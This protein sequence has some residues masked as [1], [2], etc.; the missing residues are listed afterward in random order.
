MM[1]P[2]DHFTSTDP[3]ILEEPTYQTYHFPDSRD[4]PKDIIKDSQDNAVA[5][6]KLLWQLMSLLM[7]Q[8]QIIEQQQSFIQQQSLE[9]R[10]KMSKQKKKKPRLPRIPLSNIQPR[11]EYSP[12]VCLGFTLI[13]FLFLSVAGF[14]IAYV[15]TYILYN[16]LAES[17]LTVGLQVIMP[18]VVLV[19]CIMALVMIIE[20]CR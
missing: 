9:F 14:I 1:F 6:L 16:P 10:K 7:I 20:S 15:F 5:Y 2:P 11:N 12:I 18:L 13:K 19:S 17:L 8:Q 4:S 3:N